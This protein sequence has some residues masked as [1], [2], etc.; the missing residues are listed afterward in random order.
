MIVSVGD[1][2]VIKRPPRFLAVMIRHD[3]IPAPLLRRTDPGRRQDGVIEHDI[4]HEVAVQRK[5]AMVLFDVFVT[6]KQRGSGWK[7]EPRIGHRGHGGVG[8]EEGVQRCLGQDGRVDGLWV[9]EPV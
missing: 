4:R 9:W 1:D 6:R 3:E 7:G 8:V 2:Q 5:I